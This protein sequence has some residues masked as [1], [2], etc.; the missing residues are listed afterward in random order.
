MPATLGGM[1][2]DRHCAM[3]HVVA[4]LGQVAPMGRS[5]DGDRT[6]ARAAFTGVT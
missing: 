1:A 2:R 4:S 3:L 6:S 5:Y